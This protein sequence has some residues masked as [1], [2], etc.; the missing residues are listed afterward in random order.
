MTADK[1]LWKQVRGAF[2]DGRA[3]LSAVHLCGIQPDAYAL[4]RSAKELLTG[5]P[6]V[7]LAELAERDIRNRWKSRRE[8]WKTEMMSK[9][10]LDNLLTIG[11]LWCI[12]VSRKKRIGKAVNIW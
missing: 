5:E 8:E 1:T 6:M 4:F 11:Y 10:F 9:L 12:L 3:D 2:R 7:G